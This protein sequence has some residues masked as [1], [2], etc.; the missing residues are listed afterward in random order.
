MSKALG[1]G[2]VF[3]LGVVLKP[4]L[5]S[6]KDSEYMR[7][8]LSGRVVLAGLNVS[9]IYAHVSE[10]LTIVSLYVNLSIR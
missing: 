4:V 7:M 1:E 6:S 2:L 5:G 3:G 10:E 9:N 8:G